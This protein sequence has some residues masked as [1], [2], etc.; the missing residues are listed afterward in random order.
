[1]NTY[2]ALIVFK[3][4]VDVENPDAV[5]KSVESL[6]QNLKGKILK[7]DKVGRKRLAYEISKF[8]D[9]FITTFIM[10][11]EPDTIAEFKKACQI[12]EDILRLTL[13]R[14][15][16]YDLTAPSITTTYRERGDSPYP[17]GDRGDFRD[18]GDRGDRG[19]RPDRGDRDHGDRERRHD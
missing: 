6:V 10:Q 15:D 9:G 12:N 1:M 16:A 13:I 14:Q 8:K 4:V 7:V 5:L 2:E 17:R 11:L 18:R 3:P 19:P